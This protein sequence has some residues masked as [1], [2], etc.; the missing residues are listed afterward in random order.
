MWRRMSQILVSVVLME[1]WLVL[2]V[3]TLPL[4]DEGPHVQGDWRESIRIKRL[5]TSRR[6]GQESF[7]LRIHDDGRVDGER[8]QSF[9]S[10]LEIRAVEIGVVAIKGY[11]SS[12]YL[13]MGSEGTLYGM[14]IFSP[15]ECSFREELLPGGYNMYRS[16]TYGIA[17]SLRNKQKLQ[18]KG[19]GN[20]PPLSQ[21]LPVRHGV[22]SDLNQYRMDEED[23]DYGIQYDD[24]KNSPDFH[25]MDP[26]RLINHDKK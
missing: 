2:V 16:K 13:C 23:E 3:Q 17:V 25:S 26:F 11:H 19:K 4:F 20:P 10:L 6:H 24:K 12:L 8:H 18:S 1:L 9:H 5:Q 21:F 15:E 7:Y 22:Q 14:N